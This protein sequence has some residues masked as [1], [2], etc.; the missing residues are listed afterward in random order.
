MQ[1]VFSGTWEFENTSSHIFFPLARKENSV[2]C[3]SKVPRQLGTENLPVPHLEQG[4]ISRNEFHQYGTPLGV[5]PKQRG[6]PGCCFTQPSSPC[7][8]RQLMK[9]G[10]W[11]RSQ[12]AILF[13]LFPI[14]QEL[15]GS[16]QWAARNTG[17]CREEPS[18]WTA[19]PA[20]SQQPPPLQA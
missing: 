16:Q 3:P 12:L 17:L 14:S 5:G 11:C 2:H 7:L 10:R 19:G 4:K 6:S 13:A 18:H 9:E 1:S 20:G 15:L 8:Q